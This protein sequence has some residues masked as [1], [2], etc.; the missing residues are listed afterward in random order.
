MSN[1]ATTQTTAQATEKKDPTRIH[2]AEKLKFDSNI[3][4]LFIN[5]IELTQIVDSLF[6]PAMRDYVGCKI[7]LN[8][9]NTMDLPLH[10]QSEIPAGSLYVSLYFKDCSGSVS[11]CP[12]ENLK[13][14][15]A[16]NGEKKSVFNTLQ[17]MSGKN[18]GRMY[19]VTPE[20]YE[21]LDE[22]RFFPQRK[23]NW[24]MLTTEKVV[25]YGFNCAM[26]QENIVQITGLDLG[27]ILNEVYGNRTEDGIFQ[28]QAIPVQF[29]A[30]V[31]GEYLV[32]ITQL[33]VRK[34]DDMR[35]QMGGPVTNTEYHQ[36][37]R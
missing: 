26:S 6:G 12:I 2:V 15:Y 8:T 34:L 35:R 14:R 27:K 25:S 37:V 13:P 22:F 16:A 32:Q 7:S 33:D 19:E 17:V 21:A 31:N 20:T 24:N 10:V 4:S 5:T 36:Y 29:V 30:N 3:K 18:A 28:Y 1:V 11:D 9:G 23:T